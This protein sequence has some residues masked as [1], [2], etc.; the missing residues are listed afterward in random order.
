M[1]NERRKKNYACDITYGTNNEFGFDYLRDNMHR[2]MGSRVQRGHNFCVVDEI[3]SI[4]I[5]EA[6]T[7]LIISGAAEDDKYKALCDKIA[8]AHQ[9]GQPM[10]VGTVS[11]EKS[12]TVSKLLT[13]PVIRHDL[14]H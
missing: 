10:L 9:K 2:E 5:D 6:R 13:R 7:P 8:E 4:L 11:I 14:L 3:D 12:E 1:D